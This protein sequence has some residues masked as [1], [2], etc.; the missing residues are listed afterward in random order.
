MDE[1]D[2]SH[3][4]LRS[5]SMLNV[6]LESNLLEQIKKIQKNQNLKD[7]RDV[8][9]RAIQYYYDKIISE[10]LQMIQ[11]NDIERIVLKNHNYSKSNIWR[12]RTGSDVVRDR[13]AHKI[14]HTTFD[15][16]LDLEKLEKI[17]VA[18]KSENLIKKLP[19]HKIYNMTGAGM[20]HRFQ[21]KIL[22]VK[23]SL[24]CLSKLILE[25]N[26]PWVDL[27]EFKNYTLE[28]AK[29]FIKKF[30][31]SLIQ[32]KF[33]VKT[34]FPIIKV[35]EFKSD[36][37]SYLL[38]ARS[39]KRFTEEFVGRKL[40]K[41]EGVQLGGACFELGLI[42]AKIPDSENEKSPGNIYVTLSESGQEFVSYKNQ[43]IDFVYKNIH[44][45]PSSIFSQQERE[46][47]LKKILPKF[48]FENKFVKYLM[49]KEEIPH[50]S[51][52]KEWFETEFGKFCA[53]EFPDEHIVL[54][55]N[56]I[57]IHSNTIMSRLME[58]EIFTKDPK[59]KSGPYTRIKNTED[60][61]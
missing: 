35:K 21:N 56:T 14:P 53:S 6:F 41:Y 5:G 43:L 38:L 18:I 50:S 42:K 47:Y 29:I 26:S 27:N 61:L 10:Q 31:S 39:A 15:G 55:T 46:F 40:Q 57:R 45:E 36:D 9:I 51:K 22:P 52:I 54:Q 3:F 4:K 23:F 1:N 8:V 20:I 24:M 17:L 30:D 28:S 2:Q 34:G 44:N 13:F 7:E 19:Q 48:N 60:L 58:F 49:T 37:D 32:E 16:K 59:S 12:M 11:K 33:K 25:Q